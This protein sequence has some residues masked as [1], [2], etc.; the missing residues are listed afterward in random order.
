MSSASLRG[1]PDSLPQV[2]QALRHSRVV[3]AF[4]RGGGRVEIRRVQRA[5]P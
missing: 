5:T 3:A 1:F 4:G 2:A